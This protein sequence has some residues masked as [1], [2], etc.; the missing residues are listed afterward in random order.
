[1]LSI[2]VKSRQSNSSSVEAFCLISLNTK[3]IYSAISSQQITGKNS[4]SKF[5]CHEKFLKYLSF[6]IDFKL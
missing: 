5:N 1:M 3:S 2:S 6:G 4:E